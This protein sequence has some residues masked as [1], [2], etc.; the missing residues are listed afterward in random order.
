MKEVT[1]YTTRLCPF[2]YKAKRLLNKLDVSFNEFSL[3]L[4]PKLREEI[5][6]KAGKTSVPQIWIGDSHI[7]GC[8]DLYAL[9]YAGSL[10]NALS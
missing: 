8:D 10:L 4:N 1:I 3:D 7:G 2:C 6:A 5:A 9:H